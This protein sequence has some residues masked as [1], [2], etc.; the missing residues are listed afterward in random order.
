MFA[1]LSLAFV[2][3]LIFLNRSINRVPLLAEDGSSFEK[4]V[5][6]EILQ[7]N[8]TESGGRSGEQI[9]K[10]EITSGSHKG[11]T[12]EATSLDGYL[13]GATCEVGTRVIIS[14][15]E[16]DGNIVA[17]VYNYDRTL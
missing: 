15:S 3:G 2:I 6:T 1:V 10:V 4:A 9:V 12:V 11:E 7:D 16:Y 17:N 14:I 8:I 5:V 13:Y